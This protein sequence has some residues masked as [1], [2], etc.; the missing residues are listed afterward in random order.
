MSVTIYYNFFLIRINDLMMLK[1]ANTWGENNTS[2]IKQLYRRVYVMIIVCVFVWCSVFLLGGLR[3]LYISSY[4]KL[5]HGLWTR[6]HTVQ[7]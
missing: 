7:E 5:S 1:L 4:M 2:Q 3:Y 6:R